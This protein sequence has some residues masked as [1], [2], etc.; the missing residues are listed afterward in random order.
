MAPRTPS[1]WLILPRTCNQ[2]ENC[3]TQSAPQ[4][5]GINEPEAQS[6][7]KPSRPSSQSP[8]SRVSPLIHPLIPRSHIIETRT[9]ECKRLKLEPM[10]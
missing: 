8:A 1:V 6:R 2:P 3:Q 9:E 5:E 10:R 4:P 7:M